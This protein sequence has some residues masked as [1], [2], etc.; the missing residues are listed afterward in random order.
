MNI[1]NI[2]N[3]YIRKF[4]RRISIIELLNYKDK[5]EKEII[6][7]RSQLSEIISSTKAN[8]S[9]NIYSNLYT[10]NKALISMIRQKEEQLIIFKLTQQ[11]INLRKHKDGKSNFYYI[12]K[13]S[14]LTQQKKAFELLLKD[15]SGSQNNKKHFIA[16]RIN[17]LENSIKEIEGKLSEFN[18]KNKVWIYFN[19][20]LSF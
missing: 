18:N 9:T 6:S 4:K 2:F 12:Y 13:L 1:V 19:P 8:A 14:N 10:V 7:N 5:I 17:E 15:C 3:K 20:E 16:V 11:K